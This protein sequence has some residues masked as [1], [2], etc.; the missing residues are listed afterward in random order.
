MDTEATSASIAVF[1]AAPW[2]VAG[3]RKARGPRPGGVSSVT[4]LR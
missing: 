1:G 4:H 3:V 2:R